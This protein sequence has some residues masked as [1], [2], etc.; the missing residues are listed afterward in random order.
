MIKDMVLSDIKTDSK[1]GKMLVAAIAILTTIEHKNIDSGRFG[2][3]ITPED[4][5]RELSKLANMLYYAEEYSLWLKATKRENLI[6]DILN[7][8]RPE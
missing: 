1:E 8:K 4:A 6:S 5:I 2:S 7:E 3:S